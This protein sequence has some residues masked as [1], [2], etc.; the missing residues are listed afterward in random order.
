MLEASRGAWEGF[1]SP[2]VCLMPASV[3]AEA[4]VGVAVPE[5]GGVI[6]AGAIAVL[7]SVSWGG[8]EDAV[9]RD[10]RGLVIA[11]GEVAEAV[12]ESLELAVEG[13]RG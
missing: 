6:A 2:L 8:T 11:C 3:R 13:R 9:S 1:S 7:L 10:L 12:K 5:P 4:V